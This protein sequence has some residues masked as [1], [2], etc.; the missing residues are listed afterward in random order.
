MSGARVVL[1]RGLHTGIRFV[2]PARKRAL[3]KLGERVWWSSTHLAWAWDI[4]NSQRARP[5]RKERSP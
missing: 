4:G 5:G 3:R 1:F 2:S